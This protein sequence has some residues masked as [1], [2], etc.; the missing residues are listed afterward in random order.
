[1]YSNNTCKESN[2]KESNL[3]AAK[4]HKLEKRACN[5]RS[6]VILRGQAKS[7]VL[8]STRIKAQHTEIPTKRDK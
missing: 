1:M 4:L 3:Q 5:C 6:Q 2:C 8:M 7:Y